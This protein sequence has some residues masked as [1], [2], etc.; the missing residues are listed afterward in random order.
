VKNQLQVG[1]RIQYCHSNGTKTAKKLNETIYVITKVTPKRAVAESD[2]GDFFSYTVKT[3]RQIN[4]AGKVRRI[5][6]YSDVK[7]LKTL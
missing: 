6:Q 5:G 1:D 2:P 3:E 7:Y 4:D